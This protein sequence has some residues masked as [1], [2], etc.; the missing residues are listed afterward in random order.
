ML[1]YGS[2]ETEI[3]LGKGGQTA[4]IIT[5]FCVH[6]YLEDEGASSEKPPSGLRACLMLSSLS[7]LLVYY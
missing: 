1:A 2:G 4:I 7:D 6:G 3:K 5:D